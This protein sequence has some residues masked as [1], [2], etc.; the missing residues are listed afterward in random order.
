M[1]NFIT[2]TSIEE[3]WKMLATKNK[4]ERD[5]S[6]RFYEREHIYE[7]EGVTTG[8]TSVTTMIH[9]LFPQFDADRVIRNMRARNPTLSNTIYFGMTDDEIRRQ[10]RNNGN[11]SASSGTNMHLGIEMFMNNAEQ[12]ID[13]SVLESTEWSY[14]QN[15][16]RDFGHDYEPYR[17]EWYVWSKEAKLA[18]S[19]DCVMKRK[20]DGKYIIYDWKRTKEIKM[21]NQ[22]EGGFEPVEHLPN[23]NYWHY[24]IQLN[25]YK[26]IL[27]RYYNISIDEMYLLILHPNNS[28]YIKM[29][30]NHLKEE[31]Q[32]I[33]NARI[34]RQASSL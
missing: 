10:W 21:D 24:T 33:M 7:V 6:I 22:F 19:I 16:W 15:F 8:Y 34:A 28:N 3:D 29:K 4:H 14:F 5:D 27:E 31:I 25:I 12:N 9:S 17:T 2:N 1:A 20:S 26:W 13:H 32:D 18:G 23:C 30:L 11:A